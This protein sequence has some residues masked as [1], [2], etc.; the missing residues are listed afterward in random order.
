MIEAWE[1]AVNAGDT[2]GEGNLGR[3]LQV[4]PGGV[5]NSQPLHRWGF[6]FYP[7]SRVWRR[8]RAARDEVTR[9]QVAKRV[10]VTE[11]TLV[12][13]ELAACEGFKTD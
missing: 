11:E 1:K 6:C 5:T 7:L 10:G 9:E 2:R 12:A 3:L 8:A 4:G 13:W